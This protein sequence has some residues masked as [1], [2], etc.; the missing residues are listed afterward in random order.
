MLSV[1]KSKELCSIIYHDIIFVNKIDGKKRKEK[2]ETDDKVFRYKMVLFGSAGVGKTSLVERYVNDKFQENYI[3]TLGYNM[4]EK[5][6][7]H[8][9]NAVSLMIYDIGGQ[10]RFA[11]LRK[12]YAQGASTA[13]IVYDI[14]DEESFANVK[15]WKEDLFNFAGEV[16]F[17]IIGNKKDLEEARQVPTELAMKGAMEL[18]ALHFFE[19]SAKTGDGVE[20]AFRQ[21]AIKTYEIRVV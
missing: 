10:E 2:M 14:T 21:L 3:S 15:N 12:K 13:F 19:T 8:N 4:Y 17:I 6:I 18:D 5:W 9:G 11:E 20:E 1:L 7:S 16:P